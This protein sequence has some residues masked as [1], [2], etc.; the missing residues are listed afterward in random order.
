MKNS[1]DLGGCYPPPPL[2][3]VNNTL[4]DLQNSLYPTQPHSIVANYSG[5]SLRLQIYCQINTTSRRGN[6]T[7]GILFGSIFLLFSNKSSRGPHSVAGQNPWSL[8]LNDN[9]DYSCLVVCTTCSSNAIV[10]HR[11][12]A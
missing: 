4:L 2:A 7:A 1:A 3:L 11:S 6:Q 9:P 8:A 10:H 5:L 12:L